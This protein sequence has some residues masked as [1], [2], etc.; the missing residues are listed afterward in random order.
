M[1]LWEH[2]GERPKLGTFDTQYV[3]T[4]NS[5]VSFPPPSPPEGEEVILLREVRLIMTRYHTHGACQVSPLTPPILELKSLLT[6]HSGG[7]KYR[8]QNNGCQPAVM[9]TAELSYTFAH[10]AFKAQIPCEPR[11]CKMCGFTMKSKKTKQP[12]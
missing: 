10:Q 6:L 5:H 12:S 1:K 11:E 3:C 8:S 7:T 4:V 2:M 9:T